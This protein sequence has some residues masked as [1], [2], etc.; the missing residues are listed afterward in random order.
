MNPSIERWWSLLISL[1][2]Y[3]SLRTTVTQ[4][5]VSVALEEE[6]GRVRKS[7]SLECVSMQSL[8]TCGCLLLMCFLFPLS[9]MLGSDKDLAPFGFQL[10]SSPDWP[11]LCWHTKQARTCS[12]P[13]GERHG[14]ACTQG[15]KP[16]FFTE[17]GTLLY[18][19]S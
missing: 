4:T 8:P 1:L 19:T 15:V 13:E 14:T 17:Q 6:K 11:C 2:G 9:A 16:S 7:I 10:I 12:S 3:Q 18:K 5:S